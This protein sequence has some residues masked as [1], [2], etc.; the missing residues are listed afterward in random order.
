[1]EFVCSTRAHGCNLGSFDPSRG[2]FCSYAWAGRE[3]RSSDFQLLLNPAGFE[4]LAW[5]DASFG[6]APPG[7]VQGCPRSDLLVGR[8]A[9]GLGKVSK[10]QQA[11]FVAAEGEEVWYKW[12]Q[13]LAV[14]QGALGVSIADVAYE[15][16]A[17]L[18]S[19]EDEELA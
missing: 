19:A 4:A 2:P 3:L 18:E 12:Y 15:A 17:A 8:S 9:E 5:A 10:E 11:L 14:R 16:A 1:P 7:A 6:S 13:V